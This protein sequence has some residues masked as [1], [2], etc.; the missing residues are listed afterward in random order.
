LKSLY[1]ISGSRLNFIA[2]PLTTSPANDNPLDNKLSYCSGTE[3]WVQLGVSTGGALQ[4]VTG[5][6]KEGYVQLRSEGESPVINTEES[7]P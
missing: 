6:D 7:C 2:N 1:E 3:G 5:T 4:N